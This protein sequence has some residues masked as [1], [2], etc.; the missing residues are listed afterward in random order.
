MRCLDE[1]VGCGQRLLEGRTDRQIDVRLYVVAAA[2]VLVEQ[3]DPYRIGANEQ[4]GG[5]QNED[6]AGDLQP[7]VAHGP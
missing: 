2:Q 3:D 5:D 4:D 6:S 1:A 7:D